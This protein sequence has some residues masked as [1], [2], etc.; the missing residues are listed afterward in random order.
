MGR[1]L[2]GEV[3]LYADADAGSGARRRARGNMVLTVLYVDHNLVMTV[4]C[5]DQHLVLT[6]AHVDLN[7]ILTVL[8]AGQHPVL[9]VLCVVPTVLH[10]PGARAIPTRTRAA[11]SGARRRALTVL[12]VP[13]LT[14]LHVPVLMGLLAKER[15]TH[16]VARG[17]LYSY[18]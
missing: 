9:T 7:L 8:H 2:M 15:R 12:H 18:E 11:G 14:V 3:P 1:F 16:T 4:V 6:V 13:V 10:V 5:V 17:G